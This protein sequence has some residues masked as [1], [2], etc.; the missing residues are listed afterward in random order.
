VNYWLKANEQKSP[1]PA[2]PEGHRRR[3]H[4]GQKGDERDKGQL[5]KVHFV[6]LDRQ[7]ASGAP[8]ATL[9]EASDPSGG[10]SSARRRHE[11]Y[12]LLIN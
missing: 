7:A 2:D 5:C 11:R 12:G 9:G 1:T 10:S 3:H 4:E 8:S 6:H